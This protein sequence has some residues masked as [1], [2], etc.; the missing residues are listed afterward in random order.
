MGIVGGV[1]GIGG[2][3]VIS[4]ILVG[5]GLPTAQVAPAALTSNLLTSLA[6]TATYTILASTHPGMDIAPD[7][8]IGIIAGT[9]G[10]IGSCLGAAL[11]PHLPEHA[12]RIILGTLAITTA[13]LYAIP[14]IN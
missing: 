6:G 2:G 13:V 11:Q 12:L 10:L 5:R 3:S 7:W 14:A 1:Y 8:T 9:G 4:P